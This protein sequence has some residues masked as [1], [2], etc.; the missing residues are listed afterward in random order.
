M[1]ETTYETLITHSIKAPA[2]SVIWCAVIHENHVS[3]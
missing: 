3:E 1:Y 2:G